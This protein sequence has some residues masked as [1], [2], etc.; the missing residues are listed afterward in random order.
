VAAVGM[1]AAEGTAGARAEDPAI[2]LLASEGGPPQLRWW[3]C[4][5]QSPGD[6]Q[7]G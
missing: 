1:E 5:R 3:R 7:R 2:D 6:R 4:A